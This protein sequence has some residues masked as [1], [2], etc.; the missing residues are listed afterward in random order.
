MIKVEK[1]FCCLWLNFLLKFLPR[2]EGAACTPQGPGTAVIPADVPLWSKTISPCA[3]LPQRQ[4]NSL[5]QLQLLFSAETRCFQR[6]TVLHPLARRQKFSNLSSTLFTSLYQT[7]HQDDLFYEQKIPV[8]AVLDYLQIKQWH[9]AILSKPNQNLTQYCPV[10]TSYR[11]KR[12]WGK[13]I[14]CSL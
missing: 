8:N 1:H 10:T 14:F 9:A 11:K 4:T 5:K 3:L 7:C 13:A 2:Q 6:A 12:C